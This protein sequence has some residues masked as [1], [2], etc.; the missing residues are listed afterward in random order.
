VL[1]RAEVRIVGGDVDARA[2]HWQ[3]DDF[4]RRQSVLKASASAAA[5]AA[6]G[7]GGG[8]GDVCQHARFHGRLGH[9]LR[10]D[11]VEQSGA[12]LQ[13]LSGERAGGNV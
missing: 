7:G 9:A 8:N 1:Q 4:A 3:Q 5:A 10:R 2:I 6:G 13:H 11:Y 12:R